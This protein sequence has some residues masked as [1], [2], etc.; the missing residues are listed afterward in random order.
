MWLGG[1][2]RR[3]FRCPARPTRGCR[4][5]RAHAVVQPFHSQ[6][7]N[8]I[9]QRDDMRVVGAII[10]GVA[11]AALRASPADGFS[12]I[13]CAPRDAPLRVRSTGSHGAAVRKVG[14]DAPTRWLRSWLR[15][16]ATAGAGR[17]QAARSASDGCS[18]SASPNSRAGC[19]R[20]PAA[21]GLAEAADIQPSATSS[22]NHEPGD[23]A[24]D[25]EEAQGRGRVEGMSRAAASRAA[26]A[27]RACAGRRASRRAALR[28]RNTMASDG[29]PSGRPHEWLWQRP[30]ATDGSRARTSTR[31]RSRAHRDGRPPSERPPRSS[32]GWKPT[33]SATSG[34]PAA[35]AGVQGREIRHPLRARP[36]GFAL[37]LLDGR[38]H[39]PLR[40]SVRSPA[41][42]RS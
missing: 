4:S 14:T 30:L 13:S 5:C 3:R 34:A 12:C 22:R 16:A 17:R 36:A 1:T 35:G 10:V 23:P 2:A 31:L 40:P 11:R 20:S 41:R 19:V 18:G 7:S 33:Q 42:A 27:T 6:L 39:S 21:R 8:A 9:H 15:S 26:A 32:E 29:T 25:P 37:R 24:R 38:V 28:S